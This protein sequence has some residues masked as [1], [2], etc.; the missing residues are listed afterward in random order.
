MAPVSLFQPSDPAARRASTPVRALSDGART[1]PPALATGP[2]LVVAGVVAAILLAVSNR[3]GYHRDELYFLEA[4]QHPAW[5]YPD[6]PPFT[7]LVARAMSA[8]GP[9]SLVVLRVP[10]MLAAFALVF[11]T[12]LISRELGGGRAAQLLAAACVGFSAS[13]FIIFHTL[14][15]T[16]FDVLFWAVSSWLVARQLRGADPRGWLVVGAVLG[17]GLEN[18]TLVAFFAVAVIAGLLI[19]GPRSVLRSRWFWAGA[20][21]SVLLWAPNLLWQASHGWPQLQ[22]SA[23]IAAGGS[24]SSQPWYLF[25]PLELVLYSPLY[26]PVWGTGLVVLLRSPALRP[27]RC[28]GWAFLLLAVLFLITGGKPYYLAGLYPMLFGAGAQPVV[29]WAARAAGGLRRGLL[30]AMVAVSLLVT[31]YLGLPLLPATALDGSPGLAVNPDAG[32]TVGWPE[33]ADTVASVYP[34]APPG[35]V[36]L[37]R[38]YGEA[39][40]LDRFG[41]ALGLPPA[42]SG[43][44][45][46]GLWGPPLSSATSAVVVGYPADELSRW[47]DSCTERA[48][49][50]NRV[51]LDNAEQGR[52]V[53]VC[54]GLRQSWA[55]L[56]PSIIRLG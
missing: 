4:G 51:D 47:F 26:I 49:I 21:V 50:D 40:A 10:S 14:G 5:G 18:K 25:I 31:A 7:P 20:A 8:L 9:D 23:S 42:F 55:A 24:T 32:E 38:N 17:V 36:L 52:P 53:F 12:G 27:Y 37:T 34:T 15:T 29:Q 13:T 45:G 33:F 1:A 6:Q 39:G 11:V 48:T 19:A 3:Y 41:P 56:W 22:L 54:T 30:V 28:F 2:L 35:S 43:H 44:N 16:A 46:Y